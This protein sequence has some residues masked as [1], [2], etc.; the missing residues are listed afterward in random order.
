MDTKITDVARA[1]GVS[2]ATVSRVM[3][4]SLNV[5]NSTRRKVANAISQLQYCPNPYAAELR[6]GKSEADKSIRPRYQSRSTPAEPRSGP[7]I[8][9]REVTDREQ[10]RLQFLESEC[11]KL[12]GLVAEL[13]AA[14]NRLKATEAEPKR[15]SRHQH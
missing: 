9:H 15:I 10:D 2:T 12:R 5:S 8:A 1:A 14:L 3:N 7:A 13:S 4:G 6:R 11:S